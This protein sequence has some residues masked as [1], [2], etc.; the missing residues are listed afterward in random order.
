[1]LPKAKTHT[2]THVY[3]HTHSHT[4]KSN[5]ALGLG[6]LE[7]KAWK[8]QESCHLGTWTHKAH[9][10]LEKQEATSGHLRRRKPKMAMPFKEPSDF[11][12]GK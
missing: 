6:L 9:T 11:G 3:A 7:A 10:L 2:Y 5:T 1:M 8:A 4:H 12:V